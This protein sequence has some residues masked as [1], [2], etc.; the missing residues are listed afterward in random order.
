MPF[1]DQIDICIVPAHPVVMLKVFA[2]H[3]LM[4]AVIF[5]LAGQGV[6]CASTPCE[7]M[8]PTHATAMAD[9]PDCAGMRDA[10]K[11]KAPCKDMSLG[12]FAMAGC[13][14]IVAIDA[15]PII[16][17]TAGKLVLPN[18]PATPVLTGRDTAPDPDPPSFLG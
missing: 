1:R 16:A 18:W 2:R 10:P 12:C 9:M 7:E 17:R 14:A 15:Q 8:A 3:L 13:S 11:G 5:G 4:I 6:A